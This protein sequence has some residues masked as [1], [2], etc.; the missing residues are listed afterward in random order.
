MTK[1]I[2]N[3]VRAA[4]ALFLLGLSLYAGVDS[5]AARELASRGLSSCG[6]AENPCSLAPL[7]VTV[8][9]AS[10]QMVS[11]TAADAGSAKPLGVAPRAASAH[12]VA[13]AES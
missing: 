4:F 6:T 8:A 2:A 10:G 9:K 5:L 11:N 13:M 3:T 12:H 7:T 1:S